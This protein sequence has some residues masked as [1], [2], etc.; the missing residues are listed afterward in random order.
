MAKYGYEFDPFK[1]TGV[2]VP[3]ENREDA[4]ADVANFLREEAL[5]YIGSGKSPVKD[6]PWKRSLSSGYK[7][8]KAE[9]SSSVFANLELSGD[10]LD[11]LDVDVKANKLFYGVSG[12]QAGKAEGNNI[13]S[14]GRDEDESKARRFIPIDGE[15]F[16]KPILDGIKAILKEYAEEE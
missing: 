13:G 1:L 14:Y 3:K 10:L 7:P 11:A 12:D 8:K 5:N 16:K 2:K 6:G 15:T 9:E 4:L